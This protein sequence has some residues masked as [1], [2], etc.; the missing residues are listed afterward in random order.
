MNRWRERK[1]GYEL[2][3]APDIED[4]TVNQERDARSCEWVEVTDR[5]R[6]ANS[7]EVLSARLARPSRSAGAGDV[8]KRKVVRQFRGARVFYILCRQTVVRG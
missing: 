8:T 2:K 6:E 1:S 7:G 5:P 3:R 4:V